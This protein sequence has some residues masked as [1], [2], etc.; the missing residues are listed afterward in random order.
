MTRKHFL[1][2]YIMD[3]ILIFVIVYLLLNSL[4]IN[5]YSLYGAL[6]FIIVSIIYTEVKVNMD[7]Y[8][9]TS[10]TLIHAHGILSKSVKKISLVAIS[11]ASSSQNLI[12]R[13]LGYG[14]VE[15]KMFSRDVPAHVKYI[16]NPREFVDKIEHLISIN[17]KENVEQ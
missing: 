5:K 14:N 6:L 1:I 7:S 13:I 4:E 9:L 11:D 3:L 17:K 15:V 16:N 2:I 8:K 12:Q 10:S